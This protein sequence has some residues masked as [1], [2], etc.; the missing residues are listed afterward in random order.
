M[1]STPARSSGCAPAS[2]EARGLLRATHA[3][4]LDDDDWFSML[5]WSSR[6]GGGAGAR[7]PR[8]GLGGLR[9]AGT[10]AG[11]RV[12]RFG[13]RQR[14]GGRLPRPGRGGGRASPRW[15]DSTPTARSSSATSGTS[16]W[17]RSGCATSG[18]GSA[19]DRAS[20]AP[21]YRKARRSRRSNPRRVSSHRM[22]LGRPVL[23]KTWRRAARGTPWAAHG[24]SAR[25][26]RERHVRAGSAPPRCSH[27]SFVI[28]RW[29]MRDRLGL[30]VL[31][32]AG[33]GSPGPRRAG[34]PG[35]PGRPRRRGAASRSK[36]AAH[37][38]RIGS[39]S[40]CSA[41]IASR[42]CRPPRRPAPAGP[43]RDR[44]PHR[45]GGG[46]APRR[47]APSA[48]PGPARSAGPRR[49]GRAAAAKAAR[50]RRNRGA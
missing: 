48:P 30:L 8:A 27:S 46:A 18:T 9:P 16:R 38:V 24:T 7:R 13:Q 22:W 36:P 41:S 47:T 45:C 42:T 44:R 17:S 21:T 4:D 14:T 11:R 1:T 10:F 31:A 5:N 26:L 2:G 34:R 25:T 37:A 3:I 49:G 50:S 20:P 29:M 35:R 43:A 28:T 39:I 23:A 32:G 15:P 40:A 33:P 6:R 12:R 19:S